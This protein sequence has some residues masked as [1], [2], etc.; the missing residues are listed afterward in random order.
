MDM[1][2]DVVVEDMETDSGE[3][4]EHKLRRLLHIGTSGASIQLQGGFKRSVSCDY[5]HLLTN[6]NDY[7]NRTALL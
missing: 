7:Y 6:T 1:E 4:V 5:S 3:I 2:V